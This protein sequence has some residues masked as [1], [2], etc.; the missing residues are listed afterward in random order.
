[1]TR[2]RL[3][4]AATTLL[5]LGLSSLPAMAQQVYKW[6]DENGQVQFTQTPPPNQAEFETRD[7]SGRQVSDERR[8]YCAAIG[9]LA[10]RVATAAARGVPITA[11]S[12]SLRQV[13][14]SYNVDVDQV[15]MRE[16]VNYVYSNVSRGRYDSTVAGRAQDACLNGSFGKRGQL[17]D[18][19]E[20]EGGRGGV[21]S[22]T[23]WISRGVIVTNHHV[24]E[25]RRRLT[26]RFADGDER[27]AR[28]LASTA[29]DDVALLSVQGPLPEGLP[30]APH[31]A[32]IGTDVFTLGY[33][34]TQIM[35]SNAKLTSGIINAT[36]GLR[37]DPR[38]YQISAAVQSGNSGGPLIN[39]DGEVV[40]IVTAKLRADAVYRA[41][42]D[43]PQNVNYAVKT[44]P[45]LKL[46][47]QAGV[48]ASGPNPSA[49]SLSELAAR[50]SPS[51]VVVLAE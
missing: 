21:S 51:I 18:R 23:G 12:E 17:N 1:M 2:K 35:G 45:V 50:F 4:S 26:V 39:L 22:G 40:G 28:L 41:T 13:E 25:G 42:G 15:A 31:E 24:I 38:F 19:A 6:V 32:G 49:G 37:D 7:M 10:R 29:D 44:Y 5:V 14:V 27:P 47:N 30:I 8:E 16:L 33:P 3:F 46:M 20:A 34:H 43:I 9:E 36:T 11:V 48:S